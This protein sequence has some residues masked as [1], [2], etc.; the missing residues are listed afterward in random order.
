MKR[1]CF[2]SGLLLSFGI[3]SMGS[4]KA[5][6]AEKP[7]KGTIQYKIAYESDQVPAE[8]L[9]AQ[10]SSAIVKITD[11]K[12]LMD[13]KVAKAVFNA[14][15]NRSYNLINLSG[16]GLGRYVII[17]TADEM[18]DTAEKRNYV[19]TL[20]DETKTIHGYTAKKA[21]GS[22]LTPQ[23]EMS[24][25][26]YYVENFCPAFFNLVE[27]SFIGLDG[28]PLEY[29]VTMKSVQG[30]TMT[31]T[32]TPESLQYGETDPKAFNIPKSYQKVSE[33]ELQQMLEEFM[34]A[35]E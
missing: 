7:F 14:D 5:Q 19:L 9:A 31:T 35:F 11:T 22:Y 6:K 4:V 25:V 30:I 10:P 17:E 2:W 1:I 27:G 16:M 34:S 18:R 12:M 20:T 24:F 28:F 13:T 26:V 21:M 33:A 3:L 8:Q 23:A 32:F 29:T 15:E